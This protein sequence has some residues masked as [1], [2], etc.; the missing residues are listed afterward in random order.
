ML[1]ILAQ[2]LD[3]VKASVVTVSLGHEASD[4]GVLGTVGPAPVVPPLTVELIA[5]G[6]L[7]PLTVLRQTVQFSTVQY[8]TV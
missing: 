5:W 4:D 2:E 3:P 8:S 1:H 7:P 6:Q